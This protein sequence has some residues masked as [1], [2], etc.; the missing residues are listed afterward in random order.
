MPRILKHP[1][2]QRLKARQ[3]R[4]PI[5]FCFDERIWKYAVV[6]QL[7]LVKTRGKSPLD[8]YCVVPDTLSASARKIMR[9][10]IADADKES[11]ISFLQAPLD[12]EGRSFTASTRW[13]TATFFRLV[14]ARILP[15]LDEVLYTDAHDIIFNG[16]L[17]ELWATRLDGNLIAAVFEAKGEPDSF[18]R[19]SY[20]RGKQILDLKRDGK[21]FCAGVAKLNLK[22][23]RDEKLMDK[24]LALFDRAWPYGDQDILN[25]ACKGR[26]VGLDRKFGMLDAKNPTIIHFFG[27][28]KPWHFS[29]LPALPDDW[30]H[31][32]LMTPFAKEFLMEYRDDA[33]AYASIWR[34]P[35]F[36]CNLICA[37][38]P[39]KRA[40]DK[41]RQSHSIHIKRAR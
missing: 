3:S 2:P 18:V 31:Y 38:I 17:D 34:V 22:A 36:L 8:I 39:F 24:F 4:I 15:H 33:V 6:T 7:S 21:Y 10:V 35:K 11:S 14:L 29:T 41:F 25:I 1:L 37:F 23:I 5:A 28:R 40:R 26:V 9:D 32:A 19:K 16:P 12:F 27:P 13:G 30:W 20:R